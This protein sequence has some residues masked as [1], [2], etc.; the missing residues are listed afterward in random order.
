MD[1]LTD[2]FNSA[3]VKK[4]LLVGQTL[5]TPWA[6][7]F[8]CDKSIGFHIVLQGEA[9]IRSPHLKSPIKL[10]RGEII[11]LKRGHLHEIATDLKTKS[12][13]LCDQKLAEAAKPNGRSPLLS[14]VS[15]LYQLQTEPIHPFFAEFPE[16]IL[17]RSNDSVTQGPLQITT[18]LLANEVN[19]RGHGSDSVTRSLIDLVFNYILREWL[20]RESGPQ[21]SFSFALKDEHLSKVIDKM[22]TDITK[23]WS[24]VELA[25]VAGLSRAAFASKFKKITGE[26]PALYLSK[27]RIQRAMDLLRTTTQTLDQISLSVGYN[28]SF[29]FSKAFKRIIG[30][31][32]KVFRESVRAN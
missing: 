17:I 14:I 24:V 2:I 9:Y 10:S 3:G 32:P 31:S 23:D 8:P 15:G 29:V 7:S 11:L 30:R 12:K 28:D 4:S 25:T 13:P 20:E 18:Q 1:I 5:Y 27:V 16:Y 26:T 19:K 22:H 21:K 6:M